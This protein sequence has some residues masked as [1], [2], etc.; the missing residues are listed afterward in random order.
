MLMLILI[1]NT[2]TELEK[3]PS[4]KAFDLE[5]EEVILD[6]LMQ[7]DLIIL[8]FWS[9]VCIPCV[10]Q[11]ENSVELVEKYEDRLWYVAI[12]D[13]PPMFQNRAKNFTKAKG[14]KFIVVLD[15][16]GSIMQDYGVTSLPTTFFLNDS[17]RII[18]VHQGFKVG[19]EEWF[20]ET[21][22]KHLGIEE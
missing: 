7:K 5:G 12:N 4:F 3:A 10:R 14:F 22:E 16:D 1:F 6:S 8:D 21:V 9:V 19:D 11:L 15:E 20:I 2:S 13:D 17:L 18:E